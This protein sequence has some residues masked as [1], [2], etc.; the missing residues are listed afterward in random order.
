MKSQYKKHI[1]EGWKR[2]AMMGTAA[3]VAG[4]TTAAA[5]GFSIPAG[6]A[7]A[8]THYAL[9]GL[10]QDLK[11]KAKAK[12]KRKL[13]K[14]KL[15]ESVLSYIKKAYEDHVEKNKK[16]KRD[17]L[18]RTAIFDRLTQEYIK[19]ERRKTR[20]RKL[21]KLAEKLNV[22]MGVKKYI[23]DFVHSKNAKFDNDSK[24]KR[25]ERAL[26]AYYSDK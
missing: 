19:K 22:K 24:K 8:A 2:A 12:V 18:L 17:A 4:A 13:A 7:I 14:R 6:A 16:A 25:I 9:T 15:N 1:E 21:L 20:N 3:T 5:T 11:H 23:K 10:R 26:A